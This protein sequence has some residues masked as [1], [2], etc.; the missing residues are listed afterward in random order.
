[1]TEARAWTRE[2]LERPAAAQPGRK[3]SKARSPRAREERCKAGVTQVP[4]LGPHQQQEMRQRVM[5]D[6]AARGS[7]DNVL[8]SAEGASGK[9]ARG[10]FFSVLRSMLK[11]AA[12]RKVF[13]QK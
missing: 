5:D 8:A 12:E 4:P 7:E 6:V 11:A 2:Q 10:L 3:G 13:E 9:A 1:M